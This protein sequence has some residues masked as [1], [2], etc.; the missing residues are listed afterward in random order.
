VNKLAIAGLGLMLSA[1]L[2]GTALAAEKAVTGTL[3]DS[4][5][6]VTTGAHGADHKKCAAGCARK[7]IPVALVEKGTDKMYVLLPAK[8]DTALP[9][10]VIDKMESQ[11]TVTGDEYEKGGVS[12][13][14]VKTVK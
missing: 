3:E 1:G 2:M 14:T 8:S 4:F 12:Y 9:G 5:C 13:L 11:V 10:D 6:F 7:G